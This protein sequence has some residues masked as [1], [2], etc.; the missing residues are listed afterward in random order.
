MIA[1]ITQPGATA[2]QFWWFD[3][4]GSYSRRI[5]RSVP[6]MKPN[7]MTG[8]PI[9]LGLDLNVR[10]RALVGGNYTAFGRA[11]RARVNAPGGGNLVN[12]DTRALL[13]APIDAA[14]SLYPNPIRTSDLFVSASGL[15]SEVSTADLE[16]IDATG[17][18]ALRQLIAVN[19]GSVNVTIALPGTMR[20][21]LYTVRLV[22]AEATFIERLVRE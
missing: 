13:N 22:S 11:C 5:V 3:P 14:F 8:V 7:Q 20:A 19:D 17:R 16:I 4:H 12:D 6:N 18:T 10:V 1:A 9:P 21:G 2:Y 15:G